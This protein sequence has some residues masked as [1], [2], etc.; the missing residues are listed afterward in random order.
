MIQAKKSTAFIVNK[1][2]IKNNMGI[3]HACNGPHLVK[4][5]NESICNRCK[6]DL[7][8]HMPTRCP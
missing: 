2:I 8:N 4:Y 5:C 6:P 3:C 7:D 1:M